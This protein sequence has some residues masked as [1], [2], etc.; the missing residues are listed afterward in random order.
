MKK[1][2]PDFI[3][4]SPQNTP[5][6]MYREDAGAKL[7]AAKAVVRNLTLKERLPVLGICG[8]HQFLAMVFGG[9]IDFIDSRLVGVF[10]EKYPKEAVSERGLVDLET[11]GSDPI[12]TGV[13]THPGRFK[14]MES[15]YEEVKTI[16]ELFVNLARSQ[17]SEVQLIRIPGLM[18]YG[19]AFHPERSG[20]LPGSECSDGRIMLGNFIRMVAEGGR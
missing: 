8:G 4:L 18:V 20:N 14:A 5:W 9:T 13:T 16:P 6:Y 11:L 15:H 3:L 1:Q 10:P 19:M 7:E 17:M 2:R 12:F